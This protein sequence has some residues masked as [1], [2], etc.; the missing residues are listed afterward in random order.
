[1]SSRGDS[2]AYARENNAE[3]SRH[4]VSKRDGEWRGRGRSTSRRRSEFRYSRGRRSHKSSRAES[5]VDDES[6]GSYSLSYA[7]VIVFISIRPF[8][9]R[10]HSR[11]FTVRMHRCFRSNKSNGASVTCHRYFARLAL[12]ETI[13]RLSFS[14]GSSHCRKRLTGSNVFTEPTLLFFFFFF[15]D[16]SLFVNSLEAFFFL[17]FFFLFS[18]F[19][20]SFFSAFFSYSQ[21]SGSLF[22]SFQME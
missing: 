13:I 4:D 3:S 15:F 1:L 7:I 20:L 14:L 10:C 11:R 17:S 18:F 12:L 6:R 5:K 21:S 22:T 8:V 2:I 9:V 19:F 16:P